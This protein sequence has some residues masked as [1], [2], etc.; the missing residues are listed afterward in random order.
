M[1]LGEVCRE[2]GARTYS[3]YVRILKKKAYQ[4]TYDWVLREDITKHSVNLFS[5]G[6]DITSF[7]RIHI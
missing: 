2:T 7:N 5:E 1:P 3:A 6:R 4:H